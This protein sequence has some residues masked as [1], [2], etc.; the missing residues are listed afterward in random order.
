M[1][2][3]AEPIAAKRT[4]ASVDPITVPVPP[5]MLTPPTTEAVMMGRM[6]LAEMRRLLSAMRR[7]GEE[8]ELVPQPGLDGLDALLD[9]I[10]RAGLPVELHVEGQPFPLP[11]GIDLSA[12]RIVQESLTNAHRHGDGPRVHLRV[13]YRPDALII[14]VVNNTT[15]D[16]S[17]NGRQGHGIIGMRERVIAAGGQ[18]DIGPTRDGRFRVH[19]TLPVAGTLR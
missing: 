15:A 9:E 1:K 5:R 17:A 14:D 8:A 12:Y 7:E 13:D 16:V 10:G 19:V 2:I 4:A 11:R 6:A 3:S 18:L